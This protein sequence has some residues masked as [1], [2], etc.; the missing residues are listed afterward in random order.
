MFNN[1]ILELGKDRFIHRTG[2][3]G[4][5]GFSGSQAVQSNPISPIIIACQ[6]KFW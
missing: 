4:Y 3:L 5:G 6:V 2:P 1:N